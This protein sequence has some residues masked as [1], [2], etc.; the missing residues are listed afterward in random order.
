MPITV[1]IRSLPS[2][3]TD[4]DLRFAINPKAQYWTCNFHIGPLVNMPNRFGHK[5][6]STT[7]TVSGA[8]KESFISSIQGLPVSSNTSQGQIEVDEKFYGLTTIAENEFHD[9]EY[10]NAPLLP[11]FTHCSRSLLTITSV[12]L[13]HGLGGHAFN[14]WATDPINRDPST[15]KCW[16]RDF[17]PEAFDSA[18]LSAKVS[19]IG[20]NADVVRNVDVTATIKTAAEDLMSRLLSVRPQVRLLSPSSN[21]YP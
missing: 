7:I 10:G 11:H 21:L 15:V 18:G 3:C 13:L 6:R 1:A 12:Y 19:T 14:S 5:A 4:G 20:Y 17:L 2:D 8:K 9:F 16:P